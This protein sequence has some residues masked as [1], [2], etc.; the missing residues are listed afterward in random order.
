L[1]GFHIMSKHL[2]PGMIVLLSLCGAV[3]LVV[4]CVIVLGT[5]MR[6]SRGSKAGMNKKTSRSGATAASS[7]YSYGSTPLAAESSSR[8]AT[9]DIESAS[10]VDLTDAVLL[11]HFLVMLRRDGLSLRMLKQTSSSASAAIYEVRL[12]LVG[13]CILSWG[14]SGKLDLHSVYEI[15]NGKPAPFLGGDGGVDGVSG[16]SGEGGSRGGDDSQAAVNEC[17]SEIADDLVFSLVS[18]RGNES[19]QDGGAGAGAGAGGDGGGDSG[20]RRL[21]FIANSSLERTALKQG[22]EMYTRQLRTETTRASS[23]DGGG[24]GGGGGAMKGSN[25]TSSSSLLPTSFVESSSDREGG[26]QDNK[27]DG[28]GGRG[29]GCSANA[30]ANADEESAPLIASS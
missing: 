19:D 27:Y 11:D 26:S 8:S 7:T 3:I 30:N 23:S 10:A 29:Q 17:L 2:S 14:S 24:G 9:T 6:A 16:R 1:I 12:L 20:D 28:C 15:R 5:A 21:V 25:R 22:F 18:S 4:I 13:D